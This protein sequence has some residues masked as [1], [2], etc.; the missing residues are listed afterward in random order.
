MRAACLSE[1]VSFT[2][3]ALA[4]LSPLSAGATL[5]SETCTH[6]HTHTHTH[7]PLHTHTFTHTHTHTHRQTLLCT[8]TPTKKAG[9]MDYIACVMDV[10][11]L[12]LPFPLKQTGSCPPALGVTSAQRSPH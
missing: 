2:R 4:T 12:H 6:T 8:H 7:T 3:H 10:Q 9:C 1:P 11:R 5:L